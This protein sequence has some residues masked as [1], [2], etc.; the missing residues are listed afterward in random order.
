[1][2]RM[3]AHAGLAETLPMI[4]DALPSRSVVRT[5]NR[6]R[7]EEKVKQI[8]LIPFV[9]ICGTFLGCKSSAT[10][11]S[12]EFIDR[13]AVSSQGALPTSLRLIVEIDESGILRLNKIETGTIRDTS[14]LADK[15][16][17]IFAEREKTGIDSREVVIDPKVNVE[18][19]HYEAVI[20]VLAE[21]NASPIR[22][23]RNRR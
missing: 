1:M 3:I 5:K 17:V 21:A 22:V 11:Q 2:E 13:S 19:E 16:E 8:L 15:L 9:L 7:N 6:K 14:L 4:P 10:D 12:V 18:T 23:I 20:M